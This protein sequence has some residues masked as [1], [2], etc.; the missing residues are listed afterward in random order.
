MGGD[1]GSVGEAVCG[2]V[3]PERPVAETGKM[4]PLLSRPPVTYRM[5]ALG[6]C[7][8]VDARPP[9]GQSMPANKIRRTV[10]V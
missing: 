10:G 8:A 9:C 7:G 2:V 4:A 6:T 1:P 5:R 3:A